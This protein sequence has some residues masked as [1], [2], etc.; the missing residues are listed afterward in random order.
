MKFDRRY[1]ILIGAAVFFATVSSGSTLYLASVRHPFQEC[2]SVAA[3]C[4]DRF[5][6]IPCMACGVLVL[7]PVMMAIPFLLGQNER[8][9]MLSI[10]ALCLFVAYTGLDAAN[11]IAAIFGYQNIYL[12][13]HSVLSTANNATG[14]AIGTGESLC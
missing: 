6:M 8:A 1:W 11:N 7:I 3:A 2:N 14:T 13:A 10:L 5:G 4:F 9:G 12:F